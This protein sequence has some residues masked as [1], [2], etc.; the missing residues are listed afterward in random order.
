[1]IKYGYDESGK[2]CRHS[3][4]VLSGFCSCHE[5]L[6]VIKFKDVTK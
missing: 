5:L 1:M 4:P 6:I 2:N 3:T